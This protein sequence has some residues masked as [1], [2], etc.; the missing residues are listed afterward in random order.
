[1]I[2]KKIS[3]DFDGCLSDNHDGSLNIHKET[4]QE[5]LKLAASLG[6]DVHIVTRRFDESNYYRGLQNEHLP[7][8]DMAKKLGVSEQKIHFTNRAWKYETVKKLGSS[9]HIDDDEVDIQWIQRHSPEIN[10]VLIG[11]ENWQENL[12]KYIEQDIRD[13]QKTNLLDKV[14]NFFKKIQPF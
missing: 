7:V 9:L 12:L 11:S 2:N 1:M 8:L 10:T 5:N 4:A 3:F 6:Y 13:N 14:K